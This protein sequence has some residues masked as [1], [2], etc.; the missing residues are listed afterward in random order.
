MPDIVM[1]SWNP[2][3]LGAVKI[4]A[5]AIDLIAY[6]RS[7][8]RARIDT[9]AA[10]LGQSERATLRKLESLISANIVEFHRDRYRLEHAWRNVLSEV[11]TIEVKVSDW[12]G[13]LAQASRNCI[14]AHKSF[15]AMPERQAQKL[16]ELTIT[17]KLGVGV[18]SI[19]DDGGVDVIR[20]PKCR[21]PTVWKY[22]YKIAAVLASEIG[23]KRALRRITRRSSKSVSE[24][25]LRREAAA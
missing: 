19:A 5:P 2:A 14:F 3:T 18:L 10:R 4:D 9:I 13:A 22:Y 24:A 17:R 6:L 21:Q 7:V 11:L 16:A 15:V 12:R 8:P 23:E 25:S 20:R 1:A